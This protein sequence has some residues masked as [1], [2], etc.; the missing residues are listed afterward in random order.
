MNNTWLKAAFV[1]AG[2]FAGTMT[3]EVAPASAFYCSNCATR[4]TQATE[5]AKAIETALNTAQ[6][7]QTQINQYQDMLTQGMSLDNTEL[8]SVSQSMQQLNELYQ[9]GQSMSGAMTGFTADFSNQYQD[10]D[11]FLA[12]AGG[13]PGALKSY[14]GEWADQTSAAARTAMQSSGMNVNQIGAETQT[15]DAL[16]SQSQTAEGRM[17]AV[18]AGNQISAMMVQQMQKMRVMVNDQIQAQ[19]VYQAQMAAEAA[20]TKAADDTAL[21]GRFDNSGA[22]SF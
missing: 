3:I 5:V 9:D 6:Q 13:D 8:G 14:Y 16:V 22:Q 11:A 1:A 7:L 4:Y 18:Q 21:G 12:E 19:N 17:Q 15:L 20:A 2:A 10:F